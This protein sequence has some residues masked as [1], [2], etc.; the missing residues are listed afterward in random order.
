MNF[1]IAPHVQTFLVN[2]TYV[3]SRGLADNATPRIRKHTPDLLNYFAAQDV[4]GPR[5]PDERHRFKR[6]AALSFCH[7][8]LKFAPIR[9]WPRAVP[10]RAEGITDSGVWQRRLAPRTPSCSTGAIRPTLLATKATYWPSSDCLP[11]IRV[12]GSLVITFGAQ[13]VTNSYSCEPD[14]QVR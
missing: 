3:L 5:P 6:A 11:R 13:A 1:L 12:P 4:W 9:L 8:G 10:Q 14:G 2:A 7:G